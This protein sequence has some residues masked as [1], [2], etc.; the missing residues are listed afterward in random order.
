MAQVSYGTITITDTN[1]INRIYVEYCRSTSNQLSGTT[2][3]NIT[4]NWSESTPAWVDGEYI[5]QRTV[6][7]KSGTLVKTYGTPVCLT[8]AQGETGGQGPQGP[9]G[10]TG[11][12]GRSLTSTTTQYTT[13]ATSATIT[14]SNMGSYTW[15]SN[16]PAY[17]ANTPAYWVRITNVYS[18][19]SSTEY[20][21]YK[22]NGI[23]DAVKTSHDANTT[24]AAANS[25]ANTANQTANTANTTANSAN[26]KADQAVTNV[27]NLQAKLKYYW[28][29]EVNHTNGVSGWTKPN[30]PVGTYAASE[31]TYVITPL[32]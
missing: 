18:N 31:L 23:T 28:V 5:W 19:P 8:G 24:A 32:I 29:N 15:S 4:V 12:A 11:A 25:T 7:E 14:Q 13:A 3:P 26:T 17:N 27:N 6:V 22:D 10:G 30:Y 9:Q 21:I 2:V 20:I 1:D 16:V